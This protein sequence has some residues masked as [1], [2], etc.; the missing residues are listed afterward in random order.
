[1]R[2]LLIATLSIL[3]LSIS[4]AKEDSEDV[5]QDKIYSAYEVFYNQNT[6]K[7]TV[8]A[9]F[10]FGGAT[11]TNLEL[12]DGATCTFNGDLLTYNA[13]WVGHVK[14][15]SGLVSSGTFNY[16]D[17]NGD[18]YVNASLQ[19]DTIAQDP[20]LDT[21]VKSQANTLTW[22]GGVLAAGEHVNVFIGSWTWG[23]D[24][25]IFQGQQGAS[26]VVIGTNQT[27]S[28]ALGTATTHIE[29]VRTSLS[30]QGTSKGGTIKSRYKPL[31]KNVTVIQ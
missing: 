13:L 2:N 23:E 12:T 9:R 15:Y 18:V 25:L 17:V 5:N 22:G 8:L 21:I 1:M 27:S 11:G 6:D 10:K 30:I 24:A 19:M 29:R 16:E 31:N 28:L 14:E 26:N 3:V 4:C 20:T 7:T